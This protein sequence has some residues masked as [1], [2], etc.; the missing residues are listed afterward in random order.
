[1][2]N[3][4]TWKPGSHLVHGVHGLHDPVLQ[5]LEVAEL[6]RVV[7]AVVLEVLLAAALHEGAGPGHGVPV[8][9]RQPTLPGGRPVA[10]GPE[11][12]KL[13]IIVLAFTETHL[14]V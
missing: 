4:T 14:H 10:R 3:S 13:I 5:Q 7:H 9:V 1:M 12:G 2:S 8:H 6:D 11:Q